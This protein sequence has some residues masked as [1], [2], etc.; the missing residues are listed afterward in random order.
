MRRAAVEIVER[1]NG[2]EQREDSTRK[3]YPVRSTRRRVQ[4]RKLL[5]KYKND[6][7]EVKS[8]ETMKRG[9]RRRLTEGKQ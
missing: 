8:N 1:P 6:V 4:G 9:A 5:D 7:L 3:D 2:H